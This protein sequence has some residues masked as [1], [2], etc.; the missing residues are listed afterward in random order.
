MAGRGKTDAGSFSNVAA[1]ALKIKL[2]IT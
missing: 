2:Y 1:I